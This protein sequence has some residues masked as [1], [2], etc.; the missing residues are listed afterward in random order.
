MASKVFVP[1]GTIVIS[2]G[3]EQ[4]H[5]LPMLVF[6]GMGFAMK[7]EAKDMMAWL[8]KIMSINGKPIFGPAG[9][10]PWW[11]PIDC[12]ELGALIL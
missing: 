1:R 7:A 5:V 10:T 6:R 3:V 11:Q 12:G 9:K 8:E 4:L 2:S